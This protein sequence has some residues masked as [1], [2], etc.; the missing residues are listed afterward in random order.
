MPYLLPCE[1]GHRLPVKKS[2]AG[3]FVDCSQCSRRLDIPTI[4]GLS[5]LDWIDDESPQSGSNKSTN[6]RW[7]PLRGFL[8]AT[9]FVIALVGLGRSG[10][11]GVYRYYHPTKFTVDDWMK[12]MDEESQTL[13][14]AETWDT[15][16]LIQESGLADKKPPEPFVQK[17]FLEEQ[18]TS[19]LRWAIAGGLGLI[20]L[21]LTSRWPRKK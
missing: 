3:T 21:I 6:R 8:A 5:R 1:C 16:R 12:L 9:C 11:Y 2:Q 4:A 17:R 20:G 7:S 15:W 13:S 19:M 18:D 10:S 14:P